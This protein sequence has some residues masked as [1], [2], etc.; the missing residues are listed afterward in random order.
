MK[1]ALMQRDVD[2]EVWVISDAETPPDVLP[3]IRLHYDKALDNMSKK[4]NHGVANLFSKESEGFLF[5]SDDAVLG[6][7]YASALNEVSK[8]GNM[9]VAGLSNNDSDVYYYTPL[10]FDKEVAYSPQIV[11]WTLRQKQERHILLTVPFTPFVAPYISRE[12]WNLVGGFNDKC[13]LKWNDIIF[14]RMAIAKGVK[15]CI[16]TGVY[17]TH[18]CSKTVGLLKKEDFEEADA[19]YMRLAGDL[20]NGY[21][22]ICRPL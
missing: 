4:L 6:Q 17:Y 2:K 12:V 9:I 19:E 8:W 14:S 10:P 7:N 16:N 3:G 15:C 20:D 11:D 18:F 22:A 13:G 1:S 21:A 5:L